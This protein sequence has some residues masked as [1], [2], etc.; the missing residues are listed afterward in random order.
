MLKNLLLILLFT[1]SSIN[2]QNIDLPTE[3]LQNKTTGGKNS[4]P[5]NVIGSPYE[6]ENWQIGT[7]SIND[8]VFTREMRYNAFSD[9]IEMKEKGEIIVLLKRDYIKAEISNTA[10][11]IEEYISENG[12]VRQ[13]YFS[14]LNQGKTQLLRKLK[15]DLIAAQIAA[16]TYQT[17]KP[18]RFNE[19]IKYFVKLENKP[20]V[21][22]KLKEKQIL[23]NL[24]HNKELKSYI[25]NNKLKLKNEQEVISLFKH[26]DSL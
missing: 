12:D 4:I 13:S 17:D 15:K 5:D 26:Y 23:E 7:V 6:N 8:D 24:E 19:E 3:Y 1:I 21:E 18:A 25:K 11:S 16:S 10:Y 20:A 2:A 9:E 14:I 22:I